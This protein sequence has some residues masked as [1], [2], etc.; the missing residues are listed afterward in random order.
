MR[1]CFLAEDV[2]DIGDFSELAT[3]STDFRGAASTD[4]RPIA[5]VLGLSSVLAMGFT[6]AGLSLSALIEERV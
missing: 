2:L 5:G 6:T 3:L 1:T 4:F